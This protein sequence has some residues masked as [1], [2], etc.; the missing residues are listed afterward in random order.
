M[1]FAIPAH[2]LYSPAPVSSPFHPDHALSLEALPKVENLVI[3]D[4]NPYGFRVTWK[5]GDDGQSDQLDQFLIVVVDSGRLLDPQDF[6]VLGEQRSLDIRGLI[7]GI[8]YEV[9][10]YGITKA[11]RRTKP[12]SAVAVTGTFIHP[13]LPL[14][15]ACL[16]ISHFNSCRIVLFLQIPLARPSCF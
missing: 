4:I 2:N 7:T 5:T 13:P 10:L 3:S 11:G 16:S 1:C 8:G 14:R 6:T 12:L 9:K 15:S